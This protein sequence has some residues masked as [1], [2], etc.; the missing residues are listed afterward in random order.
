[1][2]MRCMD[3]VDTETKSQWAVIV[4]RLRLTAGEVESGFETG[5]S[6]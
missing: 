1:M 2:K 4:G 6:R 3:I 5:A